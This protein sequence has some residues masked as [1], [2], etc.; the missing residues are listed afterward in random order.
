MVSTPEITV[1][2]KGIVLKRIY[3]ELNDRI[4]TLDPLYTLFSTRLLLCWKLNSV[5]IITVP[6]RACTCTRTK[7]RIVPLRRSKSNKQRLDVRLYIRVHVE[8]VSVPPNSCFFLSENRSN[9]SL[10]QTFCC[11]NRIADKFHFLF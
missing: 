10:L 7:N 1:N 6:L 8:T 11:R 9:R 2:R 5:T 4:E 3:Y